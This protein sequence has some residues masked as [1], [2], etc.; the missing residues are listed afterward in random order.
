MATYRALYL[1]TKKTG[2]AP[3]E[4]IEKCLEDIQQY[5]M[6]YTKSK[7]YG[8]VE[9]KFAYEGVALVH[10]TTI[11]KTDEWLLLP[12]YLGRRKARLG[13]K[14]STRNRGGFVDCSD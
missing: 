13:R 12:K 2:I 11:L 9:V 1:L 6:F 8:V 10:A 4:G 3:E 14:N 7:R 5:I